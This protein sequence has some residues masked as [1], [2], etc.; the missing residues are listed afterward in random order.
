MRTLFRRANLAAAFLLAAACGAHTTH[1][2]THTMAPTTSASASIS[3][4]KTGLVPVNGISIYYEVYGT[5]SGTPL[6]LLPG[7]GSTIDATYGRILPYLA[8]QRVVIAIEEQNH[9]RS[10]HRSTP[11]RFTD[12][13]DDAAA[14][15][16]HLGIDKVDLMGFSNGASIALQV[17]IRHRSLVRKL[18]FASSMT[19]RSGVAPQFWQ[20]MA[21][22]S[23][24]D[25]PQPLKDAF[26]K[27]NPDQALLH[28]MYEKDSER[29]RNFVE[30]S[31]EDVQSVSVPTLV[32]SGDHD[33]PTTD[34]A[35]ELS[36]LFPNAQLMILPGGHGDYLGEMLAS[37]ENS[38]YAELSA[39]LISEFLARAK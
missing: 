35:L 38:R 13:A 4:A 37:P 33:V 32:L 17:A 18:V 7:G 10:G 27:V 21:N 20:G 11:E 34:H 9:G 25:M 8:R 28:D 24:D 31:D 12:S 5:G 14:V 22:S 39:G 6:V 30:T 1:S 15:L 36:R 26:L 3:T 23:F 2:E 19:K 16:R 29:M